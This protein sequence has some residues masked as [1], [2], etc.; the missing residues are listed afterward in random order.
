MSFQ[1]GGLLH[2]FGQRVFRLQKMHGLQAALAVCEM[3]L[4]RY[5]LGLSDLP[6]E[7][8]LQI[9]RGRARRRAGHEALPRSIQQEVKNDTLYRQLRD[10]RTKSDRKMPDSVE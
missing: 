2:R 5:C 6:E 4:D 10:Q 3:L 9:G 7:K 1:D 8:A